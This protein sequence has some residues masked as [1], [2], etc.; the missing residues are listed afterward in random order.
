MSSKPV[1]TITY[2]G[3]TGTLPAPLKP[4]DVTNKLIAALQHLAANQQLQVIADAARDPGQLRAIIE[5]TLPFHLRA[6]YGGNTTCVEVQTP[7][8]L[9]VIDCGTGFRELGVDLQRRWQVPGFAG[10]RAAHVLVTHPHMDHTF[11]TPYFDPYVDPRNDFVLYGSPAVMKSFE[12]VLSPASPLSNTYFPP[13]FNL[14]KAIRH[15]ETIDGGMSFAIGSTT[16]TTIRLRHPGGCLGF[17]LDCAGK[18]F[19]FCTDHEH[20]D[21]PDA[22]LAAFARDADLLYLDGQYLA[23][24]YEG[25][26]GIMGEMPLARM[27]WGHSSV[28]ACV[29]TG[30][31]SRSRL[32]H[33]GHREPKRDDM[34][35]A[36]VESAIQ[37]CLI[38]SLEQAGR[39]VLS[40]RACMPF[41]GLT[42]EL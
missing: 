33:I 13:T 40:C 24:E 39:D 18:S 6:T 27:G 4:D 1:F 25:R 9:I 15:K 30:I 17:R 20:K 22:V 10:S 36:R 28:E 34:D 21:V 5:K 2:W 12:A 23:A 14:L 41:E 19:V 26:V 38:A 16:V 37:Q 7:D 11:G 3:V 31:A 29:A 8:A 42:V 32:L 35:L